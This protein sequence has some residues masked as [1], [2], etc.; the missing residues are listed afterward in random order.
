MANIWQQVLSRTEIG[1]NDHFFSIG[2]DSIKAI[3]VVSHLREYDLQVSVRDI[4]V[5]PTIAELALHLKPYS[6]NCNSI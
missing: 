3:Q 5:Y 4:M 6:F 1:I 2:G